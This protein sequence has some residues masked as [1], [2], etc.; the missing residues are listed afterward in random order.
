MDAARNH[1]DVLGFGLSSFR[2]DHLKDFP[3]WKLHV[4]IR[5]LLLDPE[6]PSAEHS[7][8]HQRDAEER[9]PV[10]TISSQVLKFIEETRHLR[11]ERFHIRLYRCLPMINMFRIDDDVLWGPF[12]IPEQSRNTPT[13]LCSR[14]GFLFDTLV[15]HF[16][17][18]WQS[19]TLS[20]PA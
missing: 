4:P 5:I 19:D 15:S 20:R 9:N 14:D 2:E 1:A 11:D 3:R 8:A 12:V 10:G 13:F 18:I 16:E 6:Y 7:Y 17:S